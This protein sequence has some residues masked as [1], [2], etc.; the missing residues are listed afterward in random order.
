[1]ANVGPVGMVGMVL[2]GGF[3]AFSGLHGFAIDHIQSMQIITALGKTM[4]LNSSSK[5]EEGALFYTICGGG[6]GLAV[7]TCMTIRAFP[8][9]S[10]KLDDNDKLW[11]RK[12][13]FPATAS[14]AVAKLFM[15]LTPVPPKLQ[16]LLIMAREPHTAPSLGAPMLMLYI[17]Y[18]G[19]GHEAEAAITPEFTSEALKLAIS[20]KTT[21]V[22]LGDIFSGTKM[23]N[24][25]GGIKE[26]HTARTM[27][28]SA[29]SIFKA[30]QTWK[31]FGDQV[32]DARAGTV[33][34]FSAYDPEAATANGS[35]DGGE[36]KPFIERERPFF[37]QTI[38]WYSKQE[39]KSSADQYAANILRIMRE[40]DTANGMPP[41][42]LP[43]NMRIDSNMEEGYS[44]DMISEMKRVKNVWDEIGVFYS[45]T[46]NTA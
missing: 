11:V 12:M 31:Q 1:V 23:F 4:D 35:Y 39:T 28:L 26:Q 29:L 9:S 37:N 18:N 15:N 21:L 33:V 24:A 5:G 20:D 45:P 36:M 41:L 25:H 19:P 44:K 22:P 16:P 17:T 38:T 34:F 7:I 43:G 27:G 46:T 2:G 3:S 14:A 6:Y 8:I 42:T 30:F 13:I 32:E 40:E 10:L